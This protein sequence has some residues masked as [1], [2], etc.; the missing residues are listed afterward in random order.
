MFTYMYQN[1]FI[2]RHS[3][4]FCTR[5]MKSII[6]FNGINAQEFVKVMSH[7]M[8]QSDAHPNPMKLTHSSKVTR[9]HAAVSFSKSSKCRARTQNP[10]SSR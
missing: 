3:I 2:P 1:L 10:G 9:R 7:S 4:S 8:E 6:H 5:Q